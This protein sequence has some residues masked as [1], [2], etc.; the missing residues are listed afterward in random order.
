[1]AET[2]ALQLNG[3]TAM[4]EHSLYSRVFES[5]LEMALYDL[6]ANCTYNRAQLLK[7]T[8]NVVS[9]LTEHGIREGERIVAVTVDNILFLACLF[10]ASK[11][12]CTLVPLNTK[13]GDGVVAEMCDHLSAAIILSD[14]QIQVPTGYE[15]S[16]MASG[17]DTQGKARFRLM[18]SRSRDNAISAV[19][20]WS[21]GSHALIIFHTSGSSG[22][23]KFAG[24]SETGVLAH[25]DAVISRLEF[26]A[27]SAS[28]QILPG[29]GVFGFVQLVSAILAG[30]ETYLVGKFDEEKCRSI[31]A[32]A[33]VTHIFGSDEIYQRIFDGFSGTVS[34]PPI[35]TTIFASFNP[36]LRD[37][38]DAA[39]RQGLLLRGVWGMTE[40]LALFSVRAASGHGA[41]LAKA[42]GT[43]VAAGSRFKVVG[44][45]RET[46]QDSL[47]AG[48]LFVKGPS[49]MLGY[50]Q[51]DG[52][53][54]LDLDKGGYFDTGDIAKLNDE[55]EFEF[56]FR[57]KEYIRVSGYL[58]NP[59]EIESRFERVGGL[60][61]F[62]VVQVSTDRGVRPFLF[63]EGT[64]TPT[65]QE[66]LEQLIQELPKYQRPVGISFLEEFP[67]IAGA[68]GEKIDRRS[69][70][71]LA[72]GHYG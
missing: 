8:D 63:A 7:E 2:E 24:H 11:L 59:L 26:S 33:K 34:V 57:E 48:K 37:L 29:I 28:L 50:L 72:S 53:Y 39:R 52:S 36:A 56:L 18:V 23:P 67:K 27:E 60:K 40:M 45:D 44:M 10:A 68:N 19:K 55:D 6:D 1:M 9:A 38:P 25:L 14:A 13:L 41:M 3:T 69:L 17:A 65:V 32:A 71:K 62:C 21:T 47:G 54:A 58:V 46:T 16:Q 22:F 12:G 70:E 43:P 64:Q 51:P 31:I 61:G 35:K 42:G 30:A 49:L 4:S 20:D 15:T 5:G 66:K